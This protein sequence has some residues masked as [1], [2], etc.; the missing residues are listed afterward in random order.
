MADEAIGE[1]RKP[2][3]RRARRGVAA[4]TE[5][6]ARRY[7]SAAAERDIEGMVACWRPGGVDRMIGRAELVAPDGVRGYFVELFAA[8][9]DFR[10]DVAEIVAASERAVVRWTATATFTGPGTLEGVA[11]TGSRVSLEGVDLLQVDGDQIVHNDAFT[12]GAAVARQLGLLPAAGSTA[13]AG[14]AAA[15]NARTR[16]AGRI[17]DPPEEIAEGVWIVRGGFP[18]KV[19]NVYFLR[20]GDGVVMYD[21]GIRQMTNALAMTGVQLGGI[22][23]VVL[24]HSHPDHRGAAAGLHGIPIHVHADEVADAQGDGGRHYIDLSKVAVP[25]RW[26]YPAL[27]R[28][29]DGGPVEVAGTLAQGD[30]VAGFEVVYLPGHAPG[31]IGLWRESDRLALVSDCFYT[32]DVERFTPGPPR[33]PH[34]GVNQSTALARSS[35]LKLADMQPA[36]AWP[37]HAEPLTGDVRG[38]LE[39]AAA[40]A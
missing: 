7:F 30:E 34:P 21:A 17:A 5:K 18:R 19:F 23:R 32:V 4:E 10:F 1:K 2:T 26:L 9:P 12:D 13:Q 25:A 28:S 24:S 14:M 27:L 16:V 8:T 38:Q 3:R 29:W 33:V 35:V 20:D 6:V 15:F 31:L 39:Q 40:T 37:G 36:A 22:T 11:P